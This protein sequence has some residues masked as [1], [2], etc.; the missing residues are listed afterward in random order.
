MNIGVEISGMR[1]LGTGRRLQ[2]LL[3]RISRVAVSKR[4]AK[5]A[6]DQNFQVK[7]ETE[8]TGR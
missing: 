4:E 7:T 6:G 3:A 8:P 2:R 5:P 1:A